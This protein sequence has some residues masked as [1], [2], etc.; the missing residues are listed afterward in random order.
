MPPAVSIL[1]AVFNAEAPVGVAGASVGEQDFAEWEMILGD[2]A[3][4]G[5]SLALAEQLAAQDPRIRVLRAETNG[6]AARARN[7]ALAMATGRY[8]A[9]LDAD[10]AWLPG[11]LSQQVA[12][13]Q[14][15]EAALS[16]TGFFRVRD[17]AQR[18]VEVP[19]TVDYAALLKG[20]VI[21]C[22]TAM[23]DSHAL[24]K[25]EMPDLRRRQDYGLWLKILRR[26]GR[27]Y[28]LT[29]PL[30]LH[31]QRAGSLSSDKLRATLATWQLYRQVEGLSRRQAAACLTHHL[32]QRLKS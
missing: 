25:V 4:R 18:A 24:G 1:T 17:G 28:G 19:K 3:S 11:K 13:M 5:D 32:W 23:Y 26:G 22:L 15:K 31:F 16:Y 20:N 2:D 7:T 8:I 30:A 29:E 10:D 27:A 9:F 21:G 14:T 12:F 6:G